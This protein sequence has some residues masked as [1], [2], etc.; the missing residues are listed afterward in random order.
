MTFRFNG[1][2]GPTYF[3]FLESFGGKTLH[4]LCITCSLKMNVYFMAVF[5]FLCRNQLACVRLSPRK[6]R[7]R[8]RRAQLPLR[9]RQ[10]G[11]GGI[12]CHF[13]NRK[14]RCSAIQ[15]LFTSSLHLG[16]SLPK[17][18]EF[19]LPNQNHSNGVDMQEYQNVQINIC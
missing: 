16:L 13:T 8:G 3:L 12:C 15:I 17:L 10:S 4:I 9:L 11:W 18:F 14:Y 7:T 1:S 19:E 2:K 6:C 5:M